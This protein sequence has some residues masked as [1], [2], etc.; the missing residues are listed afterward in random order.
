MIKK[1]KEKI[2][3]V[4]TQKLF[5][6]GAFTGFIPVKNFDDYL[7]LVIT[8]KEFLVRADVETDASYKQ[9][10]PYLLFFHDQKYFL[11]KR[12]STAGEQ[13]LKDKYS[14]G[15][16]GHIRESDIKESSLFSWAKREFHEEISYSG[17]LTINPLGILNDESDSV[18]QVHTGFVFI[19]HGDTSNIS[20]KSEL[21][22]GK[23]LTLKQ[24]ANYYNYMERWS[25]LLL[26]HLNEIK[27]VTKWEAKE[28][29]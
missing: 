5:P 7:N 3:V 27:L 26:N 6:N 1:H 22:E 14:M 18:G 29:N 17:N 15:I 2:L 9:I 24:C 25:Q 10:I 19:L 23:L 8:H 21:K 28:L 20:V 13:R 16:G 4:K 12:K 11:M